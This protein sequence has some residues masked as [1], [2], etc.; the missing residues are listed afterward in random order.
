[1]PDRS[2]VLRARGLYCFGEITLEQNAPRVA[3]LSTTPSSVDLAPILA[4]LTP[5]AQRRNLA[6]V[7]TISLNWL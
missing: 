4:A 1:M 2:V 6:N 7:R 5:S 3:A